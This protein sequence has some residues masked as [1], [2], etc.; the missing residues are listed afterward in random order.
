MTEPDD[1]ASHG[2]VGEHAPA[3]D[4][5]RLAQPPLPVLVGALAGAI[6]FLLVALWLGPAA[7]I[8]IALVATLLALRGRPRAPALCFAGAGLLAALALLLSAPAL[9]LA[10]ASFG[11]GL[12]TGERRTDASGE[13]AT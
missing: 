4:S 5:P 2:I 11:A 6:A 8:V 3:A 1:G 7:G 13:R 10:A 9:F 12:V